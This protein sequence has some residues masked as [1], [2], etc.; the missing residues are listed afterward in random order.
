MLP[1]DGAI[2]QN[3]ADAGCDRQTAEEFLSCFHSQNRLKQFQLLEAHRKR[4]L[5]AMHLAQRRIDCLDY[6]VYQ[7]EKEDPSLLSQ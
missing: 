4:L 1:S 7:L 5:E 2:L 3:L 6:L